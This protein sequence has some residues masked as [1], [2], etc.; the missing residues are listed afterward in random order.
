MNNIRYS[1]LPTGSL[2]TIVEVVASVASIVSKT[3]G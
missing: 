2:V 3:S 1:K